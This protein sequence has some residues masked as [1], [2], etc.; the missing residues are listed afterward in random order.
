MSSSAGDSNSGN[1]KGPPPNRPWWR[2][3]V[4]G[5]DRIVTPAANNV[6]RTDFF[7][8]L[9]SAATRLEIRMRRRV[10]RQATWYWHQLNLPSVGDV[11]RVSA[12]LAA[13]EARVRDLSER[14][15]DHEAASEERA[16]RVTPTKTT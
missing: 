5:A 14:L 13:I 8:D 1:K 16:E 6:V 3:I 4:D 10:E 12:Q 15:E 2:S 7:A 9:V 11:R